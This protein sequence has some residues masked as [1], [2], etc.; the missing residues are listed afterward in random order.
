MFVELTQV[1]PNPLCTYADEGPV[2]LN[3]R[4]ILSVRIAPKND[5]GIRAVV[6]YIGDSNGLK[7]IRVAETK[8][9][10][11][12]MLGTRINQNINR[13]RPWYADN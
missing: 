12:E 2:T 9:T 13:P 4:R 3:I 5:K 10:V 1:N 8:E 11:D 7:I 6:N